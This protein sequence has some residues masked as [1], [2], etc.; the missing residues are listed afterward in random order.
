MTVIDT[1]GLPYGIIFVLNK[2][3]LITTNIDVSDSIAN[4]AIDRLVHN[5]TK[6]KLSA[7]G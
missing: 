6:T 1:G 3:Y 5:I 2:F 7:Y 4:G